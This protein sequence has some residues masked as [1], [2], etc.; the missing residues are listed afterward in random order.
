MNTSIITN[1]N[2]NKKN[3]KFIIKIVVISIILFISINY[4]IKNTYENSLM[5][6]IISNRKDISF[7]DEKFVEK[8]ELI[9]QNY[10]KKKFKLLLIRSAMFGVILF[11]AIKMLMDSEN[12]NI[13]KNAAVGVSSGTAIITPSHMN[14]NPMI[15]I[16]NGIN[17]QNS[18]GY[19]P[20]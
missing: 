14:I 5:K 18:F 16:G 1:S 13:Y 4:L 8:V 10:Y 12:K 15:P 6:D 2:T 11:L 3:T 17:H 9:K 20:F 7:D 19:M